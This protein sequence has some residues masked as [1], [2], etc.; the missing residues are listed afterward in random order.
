MILV[1]PASAEEGP[2]VPAKHVVCAMSPD[3]S[4]H[5]HLPHLNW[6]ARERRCGHA[7][8]MFTATFLCGVQVMLHR[9]T[10]E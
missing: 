3:T 2:S 5:L 10:S 4:P 7:L 9:W 6:K 1:N 8:V